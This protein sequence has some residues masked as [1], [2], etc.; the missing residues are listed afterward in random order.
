MNQSAPTVLGAATGVV[1][2]VGFVLV[3]FTDFTPDQDTAVLGLF[4][5]IG[6][7]VG[8]L[9]GQ[10]VQARYTDPK[11]AGAPFGDPDDGGDA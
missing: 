1:S 2:A 8:I 6:V 4:A 9:G 11:G 10:L 3:A 5:A 7:L